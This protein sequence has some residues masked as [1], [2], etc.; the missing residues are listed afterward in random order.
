MRCPYCGAL[1]DRVV[2]SRMI[3]DGRAIRRR[4]ECTACGKR[5]T[6][7]E[8]IESSPIL[9]VKRDGRREEFQREKLLHGIRA[10]CHKRAV[11]AEEIENT[12]ERIVGE[13]LALGK[14]EISSLEI[15]EIVMRHLRRLD[16]VAYVR[17]ASVYRKFKDV[18]E[19]E[20]IL[21][22]L[23]VLKRRDALKDAQL[24]IFD[25]EGDGG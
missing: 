21:H 12:V 13:I 9:V 22:E 1:E 4:R 5:F 23:E 10:A 24:P 25:G 18:E 11:S 6:T 20:Q 2:D 15:G 17:F 7:Y 14:S 8:Y 3:R 19:F 16:E